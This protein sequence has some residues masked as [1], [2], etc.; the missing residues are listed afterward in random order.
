MR[1]IAEYQ[2]LLKREKNT[3]EINIPYKGLEKK[4]DKD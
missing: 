4:E 2:F 3:S 1:I